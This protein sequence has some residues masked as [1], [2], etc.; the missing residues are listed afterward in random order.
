MMKRAFWFL[1]G[2]AATLTGVVY[3]LV[4]TTHGFSVREKPGQFETWFARRMR[5]WSMPAEARATRNPIADSPEVLAAAR[6]HWA[7]HCASCHANDGSAETAMGKNTYPPAPDMRLA[8]TQ[9]LTD[10]ELFYIIQNGVRFTAMPGWGNGSAHDDEDSWKL[11]CL[12]RRL[13]K[14]TAAETQAME[15]MN[16][17]TPQEFQEEQ[18]EEKFLRGEDVDEHKTHVHH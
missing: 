10:G 7:D 18:E 8:A 1:L 16:P 12:I 13:P 4:M 15:R 3:L 6:A 17:R 9:A 14:Q 11:V 2:C 5:S